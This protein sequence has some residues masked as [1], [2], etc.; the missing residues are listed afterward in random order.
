MDLLSLPEEKPE[1]TPIWILK[2]AVKI[3]FYVGLG[4]VGYRVIIKT[5]LF[6]S[7]SSRLGVVRVGE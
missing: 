5:N 3:S 1:S 2:K 4:Y 7:I 6:G